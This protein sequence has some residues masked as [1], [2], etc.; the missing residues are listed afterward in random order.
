MKKE[1]SFWNILSRSFR[2]SFERIGSLLASSVFILL[3]AWGY[4]FLTDSDKVQENSI[5]AQIESLDKMSNDLEALQLFI[6]RQK[7][8]LKAEN[9]A[10]QNL[11]AEKENL[12]PLVESDRKIVETLFLEQEKRQRKS[13]WYERTFGFIAGIFASIIASFIYTA[14]EQWRIKKAKV[15]VEN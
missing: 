3:F 11:K 2:N 5:L 4:N 10:L 14:I 8:N 1:N 12:E 6:V 7:R 9:E 15:A 13:V